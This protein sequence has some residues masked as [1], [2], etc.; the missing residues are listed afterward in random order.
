MTSVHPTQLLLPFAK[1]FVAGQEVQQAI[2]AV[3]QLNAAGVLATL[4][5]LGE[6]V[7]DLTQAAAAVSAY[8]DLLQ[9]IESHRLQCN[10]SLKLSQFGLNLAPEQTYAHMQRLC[11]EAAALRNFVRIDMEGSNLTQ[12]TLDIYR[13]LRQ[14]TAA[15]GIVLQAYLHRTAADVEQLIAEGGAVRLCKGA[16]REPAAIAYQSMPEIRENYVKLMRRLLDAVKAGADVRV[17]IATH[18][19][20]LITAT[21]DYAKTLGL[22]PHQFELQMLYGLR[23]RYLLDLAKAGYRVRAYVP[24]GTHWFPYF[25]RRLRERKENWLFLLKNIFRQ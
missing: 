6:D 13:R 19:D 10:V 2:L 5:I 23:R 9:Q 12:A 17:A 15:V 16:Y 22:K 20:S 1:R 11:R 7:L 14:E 3:K 8:S 25:Y 4:D 18:D 21:M 24:Y